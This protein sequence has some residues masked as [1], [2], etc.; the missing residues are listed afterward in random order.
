MRPYWLSVGEEGLGSS[1]GA[2]RA[3]R[4]FREVKGEIH[5]PWAIEGWDVNGDK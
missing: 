2:R 1:D 5:G 3:V 4:G